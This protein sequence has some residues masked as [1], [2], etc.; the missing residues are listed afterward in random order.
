VANAA[1][2]SV[3]SPFAYAPTM[4]GAATIGAGVSLASWCTGGLASLCADTAYAG[5]RTP[6]ARPGV[7]TWDVG[8]YAYG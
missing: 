4:A 7:G 5:L 1:G 3:A 8:A 2:F 6:F